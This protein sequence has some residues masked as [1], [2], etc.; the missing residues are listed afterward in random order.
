MNLRKTERSAFCQIRVIRQGKIEEK[1]H[2]ILKKLICAERAL[3]TCNVSY[4]SSNHIHVYCFVNPTY[5]NTGLPLSA[6]VMCASIIIHEMFE[7]F[8]IL[9]KQLIH[10]VNQRR[11]PYS[12]L[13]RVSVSDTDS[14]HRN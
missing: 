7:V 13:S 1:T 10:P 14:E 4:V 6:T 8:F 9:C 12:R 11:T 5:L 2:F 3:C